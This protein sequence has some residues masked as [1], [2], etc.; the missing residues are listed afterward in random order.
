MSGAR[1]AIELLELKR[2]V[3]EGEDNLVT[4]VAHTPDA[5]DAFLHYTIAGGAGSPNPVRLYRQKD[6]SV[7]WPSVR[8]FGK[9]KVFATAPV[10]RYDVRDCGPRR[11]ALVHSSLRPNRSSEFDLWVKVGEIGGKMERP[12]YAVEYAWTFGDGTRE[13]TKVEPDVLVITYDIDGKSAD[14]RL[15]K[16]GFSVMRPPTPSKTPIT[17]RGLLAKIGAAQEILHTD[18]VSMRDLRRLEKEGAFAKLC[19]AKPMGER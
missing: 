19:D 3:C 15:V 13:T 16:G 6:G 1:I 9:S 17:D 12:F 8:V 4:V 7:P 11:A 2:S 10:P 14:G 18:S 5:T